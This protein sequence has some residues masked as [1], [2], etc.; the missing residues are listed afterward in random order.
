MHQLEMHE[1]GFEIRH[2]V[3]QLRELGLQG[4]DGGL[5]VSRIADAVAISVGFP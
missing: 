5:G 2:G 1:V 3:G 4:I